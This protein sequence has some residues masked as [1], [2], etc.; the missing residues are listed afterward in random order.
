MFG[1]RGQSYCRPPRLCP[2]QLCFAPPPFT[3]Y[4]PLSTFKPLFHTTFARWMIVVH[5]CFPNFFSRIFFFA[6]RG[7]VF[8]PSPFFVFQFAYCEVWRPEAVC[9]CGRFKTESVESLRSSVVVCRVS[10]AQSPCKVGCS[11]VPVPSIP[12]VRLC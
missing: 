8:S 6:L 5:Q 11:F 3:L 12:R 10:I 9:R 4:Q 2:N 7:G 1:V